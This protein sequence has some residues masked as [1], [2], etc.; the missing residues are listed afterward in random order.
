MIPTQYLLDRKKDA[1]LLQK[2]LDAGA[3][4]NYSD[5]DLTII[6]SASESPN[7]FA[8]VHGTCMV[9]TRRPLTS[10]KF[11]YHYVIHEL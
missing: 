2:I 5:I 10:G 3:S 11:V 1:T 8:Y 4:H 9:V 6:K 7:G